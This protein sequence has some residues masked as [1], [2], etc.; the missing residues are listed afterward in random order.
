MGGIGAGNGFESENDCY[1]FLKG[2]VSLKFLLMHCIHSWPLITARWVKNLK[3]N[4]L[5]KNIDFS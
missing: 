1:E 2:T 3:S 4:L 5:S